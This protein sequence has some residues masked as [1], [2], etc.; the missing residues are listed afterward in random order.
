MSTMNVVVPNKRI[1]EYKYCDDC[2]RCNF[3][4]YKLEEIFLDQKM[5]PANLLDQKMK[6]ILDKI[7]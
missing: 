7:F 4:V 1:S 6:P 5:K 3:K 2:L